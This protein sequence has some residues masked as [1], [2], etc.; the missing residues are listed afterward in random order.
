MFE[1]QNDLNVKFDTSFNSLRA[2][3]EKCFGLCCVALPFAASADFAIN[4]DG[5]TPCKN[6]QSDFRCSIHKNLRQQGFKG[7]TVFECFGAG[8]KV[9]QVTFG[10]IGWKESPE[11]AKK[12]FDV[13]PIM[14]QLHEMLSYLTEALTLKAT[15]PIHSELR[16]ALEEME[17]L[18]Q[19]SPDL[20]LELD[21]PSHRAN[22]NDLLLK[23]SELVWIESSRQSKGSKKRK[24]IN[25]RS[26][27]LMGA[28][29]KSA[30]LKGA[31][32]RGAYLIAANLRDAD[33]RDAD[34]IGA[35]L[36]DA[37]LSG[38]NLTNSIFLT[39]VQVNSAKGDTRTKLPHSLSR[40]AHWSA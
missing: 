3:C 31:N 4:K 32:L 27:N 22:V 15:H 5:G 40:P 18:S 29:L 35:D 14:Q 17:R 28:N 30:D 21:V 33:L 36:R 25:H 11:T 2:D 23:T 16:R 39:Q 9:S 13:F 20:L 10:G 34:L 8:Q 12:M 38:A 1:Q 24:R 6:L 37:D 26:A 7:C 19:L